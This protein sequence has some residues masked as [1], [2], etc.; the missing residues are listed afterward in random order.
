MIEHTKGRV[1]M[2]DDISDY[3]DTFKSNNNSFHICHK[4]ICQEWVQ[5][6]LIKPPLNRK[7]EGHKYLEMETYF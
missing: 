1:T 3:Q 2:I 4:Y 5:F 6:S 7:V